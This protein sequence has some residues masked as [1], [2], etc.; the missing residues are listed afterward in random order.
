LLR[1]SVFAAVALPGLALD[2]PPMRSP[3]EQDPF[4]QLHGVEEE[5][6]QEGFAAGER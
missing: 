2:Q 6:I 3:E 4:E 1:S 5:A